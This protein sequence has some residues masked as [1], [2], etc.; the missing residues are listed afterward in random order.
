M[1]YKPLADFELLV[2]SVTRSAHLKLIAP[3]SN[4]FIPSGNHILFEWRYQKRPVPVN[5]VVY[6]NTGNFVVGTPV[7]LT[8]T[9][10]MATT[11][12]PGGV[13]YWKMIMDE[14][15]IFMGKITIL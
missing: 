14:D 13:Y 5:I 12:W 1:N 11:D 9:Y 10:S 2:G 8:S 4:L 6:D 15:M 7:L 3:P